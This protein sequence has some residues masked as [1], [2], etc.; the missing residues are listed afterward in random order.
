MAWGLHLMILVFVAVVDDPKSDNDWA[1]SGD[2]A[3]DLKNTIPPQIGG[4]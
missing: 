1:I 3:T 4:G 2:Y